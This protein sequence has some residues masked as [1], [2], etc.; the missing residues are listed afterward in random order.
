MV[1]FKPTVCNSILP[2]QTGNVF[3]T[4]QET[5]LFDVTKKIYHTGRPGLFVLTQPWLCF[6]RHWFALIY[7]TQKKLADFDKKKC[8]V[9]TDQKKSQPTSCKKDDRWRSPKKHH[10]MMSTEHFQMVIIKNQSGIEQ[11]NTIADICRKIAPTYISR[12][13]SSEILAKVWWFLS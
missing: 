13:S 10:M 4:V 11:N 1:V 6:G 5:L 3:C 7:L 2:T 8:F 9:E 12:E